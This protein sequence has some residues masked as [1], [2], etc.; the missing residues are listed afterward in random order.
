MPKRETRNTFHGT[1]W[2]VKHSLLMKFDQL[3]SSYKRKYFIKKF[4]KNW[5]LKTSSWF[6][7]VCKGA[8]PIKK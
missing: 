4:Y 3:M 5:D 8:T 1:T 7:C 6:L 2:K